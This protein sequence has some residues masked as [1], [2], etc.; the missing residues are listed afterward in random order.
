MKKDENAKE[1]G[2]NM[3]EKIELT[4]KHDREEKE[5]KKKKKEKERDE[6]MEAEKEKEAQ[7]VIRK[8]KK[9]KLEEKWE[10]LRWITKYIDK[11]GLS[12]AKLR[13]SL[14]SKARPPKAK[15]GGVVAKNLKSFLTNFLEIFGSL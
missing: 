2:E 8:E 4:I 10:M 5:E 6:K 9:K 15:G 14:A 13:S 11:L 12:C 1:S 3:L 7:N